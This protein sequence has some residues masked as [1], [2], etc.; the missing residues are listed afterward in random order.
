MIM[1]L[2]GTNSIREVIAFPKTQ[3]GHDPMMH[4]PT[5]A[6][7]QTLKECGIAIAKKDKK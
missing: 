1:I 2:T 7:P 3:R 5:P 6:D 4:A